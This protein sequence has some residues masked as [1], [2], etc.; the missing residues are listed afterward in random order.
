LRRGGQEV[1]GMRVIVVIDV[2]GIGWDMRIKKG[3]QS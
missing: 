1:E 2:S 3:L